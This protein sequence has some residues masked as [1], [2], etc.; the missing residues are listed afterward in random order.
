MWRLQLAYAK[1][2]PTSESRYQVKNQL[3]G[4]GTDLASELGLKMLTTDGTTIS[5]NSFLSQTIIFLNRDV[6]INRFAEIKSLSNE[7][8]LTFVSIATSSI[9][10]LSLYRNTFKTIV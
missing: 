2:V 1:S 6:E 10:S 3:F 7:L 9:D 8:I 5:K 4:V